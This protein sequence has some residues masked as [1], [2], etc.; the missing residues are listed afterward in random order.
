M[1]EADLDDFDEDITSSSCPQYDM[2]E[3]DM[4]ADL[5]S[6]GDHLHKRLDVVD[7]PPAIYGTFKGALKNGDNPQIWL[8]HALKLLSSVAICGLLLSQLAH[9]QFLPYN[10]HSS[11]LVAPMN[12]S[13]SSFDHQIPPAALSSLGHCVDREPTTCASWFR[14]NSGFDSTA[15]CATDLARANPV[16]PRSCGSCA[17]MLAGCQKLKVIDIGKDCKVGEDV[18]GEV[19]LNDDR[20]GE[21]YC[22]YVPS[23]ADGTKASFACGLCED[24]LVQTSPERQVLMSQMKELRNEEISREDERLMKQ[25]HQHITEHKLPNLY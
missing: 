24:N 23:K 14:P 13:L 21:S 12:S 3:A 17:I 4:E 1:A 16:C 18:V 22:T 15:M 20:P 11:R 8:N 25:T 19:C 7:N 6:F 2:T 10:G 9:P 5:E